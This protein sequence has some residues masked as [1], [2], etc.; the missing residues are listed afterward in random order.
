MLY[1]IS[2]DLKKPGQNYTELYEKIKS[3]GEWAHPLESVWLVKSSLT[4]EKISSLLSQYFDKND[5]HF[6]IAVKKDYYGFLE[7]SIWEW[8]KKRI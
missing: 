5:F 8:I 3:L 7:P 1:L 2:Y 4:A 6:V